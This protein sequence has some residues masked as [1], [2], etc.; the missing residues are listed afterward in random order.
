MISNLSIDPL[1]VLPRANNQDLWRRIQIFEK[2][3]ALNRNLL[4]GLNVPTEKVTFGGNQAAK[5]AYG[6]DVEA[7]IG[8]SGDG[9]SPTECF[10]CFLCLVVVVKCKFFPVLKFLLFSNTSENADRIIVHT[11]HIPKRYTVPG[12]SFLVLPAEYHVVTVATVAV[13]CQK[14]VENGLV[15]GRLIFVVVDVAERV[16]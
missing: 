2:A 13:D 16:V 6:T 7:S 1:V 10:L 12:H 3:Q 5:D 15:A 11:G 8:I 14:F 9:Y 4:H